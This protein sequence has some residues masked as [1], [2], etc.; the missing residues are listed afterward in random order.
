MSRTRNI[1]YNVIGS[2]V[3]GRRRKRRSPRPQKKEM[4]YGGRELPLR[5]RMFE[6]GPD[7]SY[8]GFLEIL[9]HEAD[10]N[11]GVTSLRLTRE[12]GHVMQLN[13]SGQVHPTYH[14]KTARYDEWGGRR[15]PQERYQLVPLD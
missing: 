10:H 6:G 9:A 7:A 11:G 2:S 12:N 5:A 4:L 15:D 13:V 1:D 14:N 8:T 3:S